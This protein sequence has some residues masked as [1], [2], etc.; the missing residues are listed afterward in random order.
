LLVFTKLI[1]KFVLD[2]WTYSL[3]SIPC[4]QK[5]GIL[6][7]WFVDKADYRRIGSGDV[8]E[9]LGLAE[10]IEGKADAA[11][12]LRV[13]KMSGEVFEI[14]TR[15]TMSQDQL[16]WFRAGSA[17]NYIRDQKHTR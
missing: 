10:L 7:L 16:K 12:K 14:Q 2:D 15:H 3:I 4:F 11:V 8:L 9:T 1:L 13:K 6:P 17:L 5:Q